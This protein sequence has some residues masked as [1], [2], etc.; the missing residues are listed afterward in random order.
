[1]NQGEVAIEPITA[2]VLE[3]RCSGCGDCLV[4]CPY[5]AIALNERGKAEV[6]TALCKG[7]GSCAATLVRWLQA[8]N[9][10][11]KLMVLVRGCDERA[12]IEMAKRN[13]V[14]MDK[15]T[16]V[17]IP[18]A[19]DEMDCFCEKPAPCWAATTSITAP[20]FDTRQRSPV[21]RPRSAAER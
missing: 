21:W 14:Q 6:N 17:G 1:M 20:G 7:C 19:A 18:C 13:Q 10:D 16:L 8:E 15:L 3:E 11:A 12:L 5:E 9:P 2:F 4:A